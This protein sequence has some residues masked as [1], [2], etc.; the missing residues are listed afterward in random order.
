MKNKGI[1]IFCLGFFII[2]ILPHKKTISPN[3]NSMAKDCLRC[4]LRGM[5][6]KGKADGRIIEVNHKNNAYRAMAWELLTGEKGLEY[7]SRRAIEPEAVFGNIKFNHG[8][9][10]FRLKSAEKVYVECGLVA[11]AHN[12]RKYIVRKT[13]NS[14]SQ[15]LFI[16]S[17]GAYW[18]CCRAA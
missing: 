11:I 4:P 7:R 3:K 10:C 12:L 18:E 15:R 14:N 2:F 6:Y 16:A 8:F 17:I 1:A 5:C 13:E 9:K